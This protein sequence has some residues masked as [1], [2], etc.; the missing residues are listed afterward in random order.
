MTTKIILNPVK[1]EANTDS[2]TDIPIVNDNTVISLNNDNMKDSKV[3][4]VPKVKVE[5]YAAELD[6]KC[7]DLNKEE[8]CGNKNTGSN[9][10]IQCDK[11]SAKHEIET[12]AFSESEDEELLKSNNIAS[13][14]FGAKS[15]QSE[16]TII[17]IDNMS[18]K[19]GQKNDFKSEPL[20][21]TDIIS[22]LPTAGSNINGS[23]DKQALTDA[24]VKITTLHCSKMQ[25]SINKDLATHGLAS[26]SPLNINTDTVN[27]IEGKNTVFTQEIQDNSQSYMDNSNRIS[28]DKDLAKDE[29][30][31]SPT[32]NINTDKVT[33]IDDKHATIT[34]EIK[35]NDQ[36][37]TSN[38]KSIEENFAKT[39]CAGPSPTL[40][41]KEIICDEKNNIITQE[42]KD[43]GQL[44]TD[45]SNRRLEIKEFKHDTH[46]SK[47][48]YDNNLINENNQIKLNQENKTKPE[49]KIGNK[50]KLEK[51]KK[52]TPKISNIDKIPPE[53]VSCLDFPD[54]KALSH[55]L[56]SQM[57]QYF[58]EKISITNFIHEG[59][60]S[61]IFECK[62]ARGHVYALKV[63]Q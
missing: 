63:M 39:D 24:N 12:I 30:A 42:I 27:T 50:N 2:K 48:K 35:D 21:N 43:N 58:G 6:V 47:N 33:I 7:H 31:S 26:P 9:N 18:D 3:H 61:K 8:K 22:E 40:K 55:T 28:M 32:S 10:N 53:N 16:I 15:S 56:N 38:R 51:T 34:Q 62:D 60:F 52:G 23:K 41:E 59:Q 44:N 29:F 13:N 1:Q 14:T 19:P 17:D 49:D 11:F 54:I 20:D 5:E 36:S 46:D 57:H 25:Y 37:N 45:T 4:I